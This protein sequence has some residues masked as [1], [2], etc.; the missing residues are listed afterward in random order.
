[1]RA[2]EFIEINYHI[3]AKNP[4]ALICDKTKKEVTIEEI[5]EA[6]SDE[7]NKELMDELEKVNGEL[8]S[9]RK[10]LINEMTL[11]LNYQSELTKL[12]EENFLGIEIMNKY[13]NTIQSQQERINQLEEIIIKNLSRKY[14]PL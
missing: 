9:E 2:E 5:A 13:H 1:M 6:F 4:N 11:K 8:S 10:N 7:Q 12:R 14:L 3:E